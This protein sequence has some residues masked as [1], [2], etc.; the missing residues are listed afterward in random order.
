[1]RF[2][3]TSSSSLGTFVATAE[4]VILLGP[5]GIGKTHLAIGLGVNVARAGCSV[6]FD[7][8]SN[9]IGRLSRP[10]HVNHLEAELKKIRRFKPLLIDEVGYIAVD[11]DAANLFF[12]L[13][14]SRYERGPIMVTSNL[15]CGRW[16]ETFSDDRCGVSPFT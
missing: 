9:W 11:E 16:A 8:A 10:H 13:V 1:L 6:L 4:K 2:S 7:A 14:A 3:L 5:P 12:Q 15:P